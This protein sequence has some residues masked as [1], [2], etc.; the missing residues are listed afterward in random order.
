MQNTHSDLNCAVIFDGQDIRW[1][2]AMPYFWGMLYEHKASVEFA[3]K[4][5]GGAVE[6]K[7]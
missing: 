3:G 5:L 2:L 1:L 7:N 4:V 6:C